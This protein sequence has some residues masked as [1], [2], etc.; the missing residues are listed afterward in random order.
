MSSFVYFKRFPSKNKKNRII[1]FSHYVLEKD[2]I[3][4]Y[5]I[6]FYTFNKYRHK[7][8]EDMT[9]NL[10]KE[11]KKRNKTTDKGAYYP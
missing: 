2:I 4:H 8:I 1:C 11:N 6:L 7:V 5:N 9:L 3:I 10:I